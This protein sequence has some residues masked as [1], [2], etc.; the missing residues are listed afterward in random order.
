MALLLPYL[1]LVSW[2]GF[3]DPSGRAQSLPL[4]PLFG[5][6]A[7]AAVRRYRKFSSPEQRT[8]TRGVVAA[9][10]LWF[11]YIVVITLTPAHD[12]LG[13]VS[14]AGLATSIVAYFASYVI[15]AL[16]P[17]AVAVGILRYRLYD[18]DV[19][20]NRTLVY[21]ALAGVVTLAYALVTVLG[22]WWWRDNDLIGP[23]ALAVLLGVGF[24]PVRAEHNGPSTGSCTAAG[25]SRTPY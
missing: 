15:V 3:D 14:G 9:L 24:Q 1:A 19:W 6:A 2:L 16:I 7:F 12:L 8:Q 13:E 11:G 22:T 21:V 10:V 23:M 17:T 20:V 4:L 5:S 25:R 18:V